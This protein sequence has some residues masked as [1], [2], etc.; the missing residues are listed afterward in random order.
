MGSA[1]RCRHHPLRH[2][3]HLGADLFVSSLVA[4]P[5]W[6]D[7]TVVGHDRGAWGESL[8]GGKRALR[9]MA[10]DDRG[11][12]Y[13]GAPTVG[14]GGHGLVTRYLSFI[15]ALAPDATTLTVDFP[16]SFDGTNPRATFTLTPEG[17]VP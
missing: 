8:L 10:H 9:W 15:P 11:R 12:R 5:S 14:S 7:L 1:H 4:W 2:G 16:P 13:Q 17:G 3:R 6:F